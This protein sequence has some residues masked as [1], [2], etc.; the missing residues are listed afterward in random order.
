MVIEARRARRGKTDVS[1]ARPVT[2]R[3]MQ[4]RFLF[5]FTPL[6][7]TEI[8]SDPE[9]RRSHAPFLAPGQTTRALTRLQSTSPTQSRVGK[10]YAGDF[11]RT[12]L[13]FRC[14]LLPC[15]LRSSASPVARLRFNR[16]T[17]EREVLAERS[18]VAYRALN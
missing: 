15:P 8:S 11:L 16:E 18:R 9:R 10:R 3:P 6:N 5:F 4:R 17:R 13:R 1:Y 14:A 7:C 12:Q 2:R